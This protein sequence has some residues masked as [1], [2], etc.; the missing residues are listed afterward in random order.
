MSAFIHF[1]YIFFTKNLEFQ[2]KTDTKRA[3]HFNHISVL[4][5]NVRTQ[6]VFSLLNQEARP[7]LL[8]DSRTLWNKARS[9]L[10]GRNAPANP[11]VS[12]IYGQR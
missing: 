11:L 3:F 7:I 9:L 10:K 2:Q 12:D 8:G 5:I 1:I 4:I 6:C